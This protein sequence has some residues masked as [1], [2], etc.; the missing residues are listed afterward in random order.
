MGGRIYWSQI[1]TEQ[2]Q[3]ELRKRGHIVKLWHHD[4][5]L[6]QAKTGDRKLTKAQV[7]EVADMLERNHDATIGINWDVIDIVIDIVLLNS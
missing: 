5:I 1:S 2:L 6:W 4:D 7:E 3:D